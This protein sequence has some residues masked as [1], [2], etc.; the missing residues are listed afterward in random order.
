M[1]KSMGEL[2]SE[3]VL[4]DGYSLFLRYYRI[5]EHINSKLRELTSRQGYAQVE[6]DVC[7]R[8]TITF[9]VNGNKIDEKVL[10]KEGL[11]KSSDISQKNKRTFIEDINKIYNIINSNQTKKMKKTKKGVVPLTTKEESCFIAQDVVKIINLCQ[12]ENGSFL[13]KAGFNISEACRKLTNGIVDSAIVNEVGA[14]TFINDKGF[15]MNFN[16]VGH[17]EEEVVSA[18]T[19]IINTMMVL[20]ETLNPLNENTQVTVIHNNKPE[21]D[22][23]V[24]HGQYSTMSKEVSTTPKGKLSRYQTKEYNKRV[25][26]TFNAISIDPGVNKRAF[27]Q[28]VRGKMLHCTH[29]AGLDV[30]KGTSIE[31]LVKQMTSDNIKRIQDLYELY[32]QQKPAWFVKLSDKG[33]AKTHAIGA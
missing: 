28:Q 10:V 11:N 29:D 27:S 16:P 5:R 23:S 30:S 33:M 13:E 6:I 12:G 8:L 18:I 21:E 24:E 17:S 9:F 14:F 26:E 7:D 15:G 4:I 2:I 19:T 3:V 22:L 25:A 1:E 32:E 20:D 31:I